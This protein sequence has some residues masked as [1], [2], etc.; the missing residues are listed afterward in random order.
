LKTHPALDVRTDAPDMLAAHVDDFSPLALESRD[1]AVRVFFATPADRDAAHHA[2]AARFD[3]HAVDVPDEDWARRSQENLQP[4][5]VGRITVRPQVDAAN[6]HSRQSSGR[7]HRP[8]ASD[9]GSSASMPFTIT[10][11]PSMGFGTGHHATTRLC[12][13]ALQAID[14]HGCEMLDVGTGSGILAI[15]AARLGALRATGVD[16][17]SDAIQSARDNLALNVE[18][19]HVTFE[20]ADLGAAALAPADV[21]TAN[22][23][24]TLLARAAGRL[25]ALVRP[26]GTLVLSGILASERDEVAAAY[27]RSG[28]IIWEQE[29]DDWVGV[30]VKKS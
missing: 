11:Q 14:L 20:V 15:A 30:A 21:V 3:V 26:G 28:R 18:A 16:Y 10:I 5:T 23:T 24:G 19:H 4:V 12:L 7:V 9:P 2:L 27:G 13:A 29:E 22:L 17:D 1:E 25:A 6:I 8:E